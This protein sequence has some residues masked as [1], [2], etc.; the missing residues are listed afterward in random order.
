MFIL[1]HLFIYLFIEEMIQCY[2]GVSYFC[3]KGSGDLKNGNSMFVDQSPAHELGGIL[4]QSSIELKLWDGRF[5]HMNCSLQVLSRI[6]LL[7]MGSNVLLGD[8]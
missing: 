7:Q 2:V 6:M 5:P 4:A 8:Q 3:F 1:C